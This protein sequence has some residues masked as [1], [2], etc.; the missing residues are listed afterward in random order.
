MFQ[1][2]L[3]IL[4]LILL[5]SIKNVLVDILNRV[6]I[7]KNQNKEYLTKE[8]LEILNSKEDKDK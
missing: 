7:I 1:I 5:I 8:L 6:E 3:L 4:I 2:V